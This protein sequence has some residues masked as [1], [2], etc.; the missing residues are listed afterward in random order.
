MPHLIVVFA[1]ANVFFD[2]YEPRRRYKVQRREGGIRTY[3]LSFKA[4]DSFLNSCA[5]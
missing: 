4:N 3:D 5:N 2:P 1:N